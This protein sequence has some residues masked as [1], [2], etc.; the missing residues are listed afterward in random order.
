MRTAWQWRREGG[1]AW[2]DPD[3][4]LR[5]GSTVPRGFTLLEL[6]VVVAVIALLAGLLL[7]ALNQTRVSARACQCLGNLRQWG[8]ATMLYA[9]DHDDYLPREGSPNGLSTREGWYVSLPLA[10][11]LRPYPEMPW[12]TNATEPLGRSV[13]ICPANT[14]RSNGKNLFH[15]C[16]NQHVDGTGEDDR[17][18]R[19]GAVAEPA[20]VVWLF[21]NGRRA[22]VAQQNNVH[23]NLH[24]RGAQF[25]FLD[26][27]AAR[28]RNV[29]YW[30]FALDRG[31]TNHPELRWTP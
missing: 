13:W 16:L 7:P 15:Y 27:H 1:A 28:Y 5:S 31:R 11:G 4:P 14:N 26:G 18:T 25:D 8:L 21:D 20:R 23:T 30:D 24:R 6:M 3:R 29:D 9:A 19:L 10:M 17:P 12:R 2:A 22:A